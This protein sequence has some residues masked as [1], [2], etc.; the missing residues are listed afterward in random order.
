MK[1]IPF[2]KIASSLPSSESLSYGDITDIF[3]SMHFDTEFL[4][5]LIQNEM[6][7]LSE[8]KNARMEISE[9][10]HYFLAMMQESEKQDRAVAF[11][12]FR[13]RCDRFNGIDDECLCLF[14]VHVSLYVYALDMLTFNNSN[15][16]S[17]GL[18]NDI[19]SSWYLEGWPHIFKKGFI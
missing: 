15:M 13:S 12:T 19:M 9:I 3:D 11:A 1:K 5:R 6:G 17:L 16:E 14:L 18:Y 10:F 4:R 2:P 7:K 8:I